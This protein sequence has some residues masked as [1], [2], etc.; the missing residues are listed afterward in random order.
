MTVIEP[1]APVG[2]AV[3]Y[4]GVSVNVHEDGADVADWVT[5]NVL[6]AMVIVPLRELVVVF[7]A[8]V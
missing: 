5:V 1:D 4:D 2:G 6:P 8:T 7:A 3:M